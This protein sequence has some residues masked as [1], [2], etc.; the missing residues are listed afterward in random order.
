MQTI[1]FDNSYARLPARFHSA[2]DPTPVDQPGPIRVNRALAVQLGLDPD[3]LASDE[4]TAVIAGN[5]IP[6]GAE[7]IA[8]V[9][10]G[11]QFGSYNPQLGDG[12][13]LLLGELTPPG[14]TRF[15]LQ[16]KGSGPTPYSRGGDG[17]A[18]LGPVLREYILCE[19]LH[20][21][22]VPTTRAL[23]AVTSGEMVVREG[24]LPGAV[25]ARVASSHIRI[26]TFEYLSAHQDTDSLQLLCQ[27]V[28][29]RH[30]PD[31]AQQENP[32][33]AMLQE[34]ISRQASLVARWQALGFIHGVMNTDNRLLCGETIDYGPC[35]F[36]DN[37]DP[38]QVYSSIDHGGRYAYRNQPGIAH[39]NL[40][41]LAQSLL[42]LLHEEQ[43]QAIALAQAAIDAFPAQFLDAHS[44][45]M[46][47]KLGIET[48]TEADTPLVEELFKLLEE[49]SL[50]F[51]LAFRRLAD[52]A[53]E[54]GAAG[55]DVG[56]LFSF[57]DAMRDWLQRWQQ[58]LQHESSTA[59]QR[60]NTMY[61][62]NPALIPRN[63]LVEKALQA[64]LQEADFAT[65]HRLVDVL[66]DPWQYRPDL[67]EFAR[68]P[69]SDEEVRQ[70]F[71]GT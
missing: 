37:F 58:R 69:A 3:W 36:M 20:A 8:T 5:V 40:S 11:H 17:R 35:A 54:E 21:L 42:P 6:E 27:H 33:L 19:A 46:A 14:G 10:A 1:P 64:S 70:T 31:A 61:R 30:F 15:D 4:G 62:A 29:E 51:T 50:D 2:L 56:A 44:A 43:E 24:Y 47:R 52:L 49:N 55:Q 67:A 16:L 71:C 9:Y 66:A 23:A 53:D 68:G 48:L 7:P 28:I 26:G 60:Q 32:A 18:P 38:A 12:R 59:A 34:V 65:F 57:P 25:L 22:G 63:H 13:A 45:H 39:W 41:R